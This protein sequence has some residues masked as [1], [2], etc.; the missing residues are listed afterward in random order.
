MRVTEIQASRVAP[1]SV[2]VCSECDVK[3]AENLGILHFWI[4]ACGGPT[5]VPEFCRELTSFAGG[6]YIP[7][8]E[9]EKLYMTHQVE[10]GVQFKA[11]FTP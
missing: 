3:I 8:S 1:V 2:K 9:I 4:C 10:I 11:E 7:W 6:Q 5:A